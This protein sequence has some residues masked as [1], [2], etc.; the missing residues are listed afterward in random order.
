MKKLI[1]LSILF[2]SSFSF[3]Q[4]IL[5]FKTLYNDSFRSWE[6]D[7]V[8]G[9]YNDDAEILTGM[10]ELTWG[11]ANKWNDYTCMMGEE[12]ASI[13]YKQIGVMPLIELVDW[14]N[15]TVV[16][17][18]VWPRDYSEWL[19]NLDHK[20]YKL[21][22]LF[23]N[24]IEE[25]VLTSDNIIL[26]NILTEYRGDLRAWF[27]DYKTDKEIPLSIQQLAMVAIIY[28]VCPKI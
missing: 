27:F 4:E 7:Y 28:L 9:V 6:I 14:S 16:A 26:C 12:R 8:E 2:I 22:L 1:I 17:K 23:N 5:G 15:N 25:W 13:V 11:I 3:S 24:D 21:E 19:I 20:E 10:L 18:K